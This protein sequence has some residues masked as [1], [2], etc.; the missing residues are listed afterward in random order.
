[1]RHSLSLAFSILT[2]ASVMNAAPAAFPATEPDRF[3][4]K[5]LPAGTLLQA[6]VE[7]D[8]FSNANRLFRPLFRYISD[9]GISMTVPVEMRHEPGA[10]YFWVASTEV[11][12]VS[13]DR[14]GVRV[15]DLPARQ[16]ASH[17]QRGGYSARN[18]IAARDALLD[19]LAS[20]P[21]WEPAGEPYGVYW[22]GPFTPWFMKR[23]EVHLP[24][25][26][27]SGPAPGAEP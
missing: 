16:V 7:G 12:K 5:L 8:Y 24:I 26:P 14:Q 9:H 3:E 20:Q 1:M 13:G 11:A 25:R 19:W 2:L 27:V 4:I 23:F 21:E 17:G 22:N 6:T 18:Y 10:M 15:L